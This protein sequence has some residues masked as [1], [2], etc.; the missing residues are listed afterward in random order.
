MKQCEFCQ[1]NMSDFQA[2]CR[3]CGR[4]ET[5]EARERV[6]QAHEAA[7]HNEES[8][9]FVGDELVAMKDMTDVQRMFFQTEMSKL[10]KDKTVAFVLTLF[11]GGLGAHHFYLGRIG[12]GVS[13][14]LF[15]WTAIPSIIALVELFFIMRRVEQFNAQKVNETVTRVKSIIIDDKPTATA[16]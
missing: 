9:P 6:L 14:A 11:L 5:E 12:L 3:H 16:K 1:G 2:V 4:K 7:Q 13:Y 15:C 10:R 8:Q